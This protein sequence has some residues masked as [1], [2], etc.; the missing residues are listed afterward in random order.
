MTRK[1]KT[2]VDCLPI[3]YLSPY[4]KARVEADENADGVIVGTDDNLHAECI[5][6][7]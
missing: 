3:V 4:S 1:H 6:L 5:R 7:L 2:S